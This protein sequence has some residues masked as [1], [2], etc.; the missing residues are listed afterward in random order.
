MKFM[1]RVLHTS[2]ITASIGISLAVVFLSCP[3][4]E[5]LG[6]SAYTVL[7]SEQL[8][9]E[10][11]FRLD[12]VVAGLHR[13]QDHA[14]DPDE[15]PTAS[16]PYQL[17]EVNGH[18]YYDFPPGTSILCVPLVGIMNLLGYG[19]REPGG[20]WTQKNEILVQTVLAAIICAAA[21]CVFFLVARLYLSTIQ[22]VVV[23]L[24]TALGTQIWST[25]SR[26]LW[27]HTWAILLGAL[28]LLLLLYRERR[29]SQWS[30][31]VLATT[32]SW[33]VFVRPSFALLAILVAVHVGLRQR[34]QFIVFMGV[35]FLWILVLYAYSR[36]HFH[37]RLPS[38][39]IP[40]RILG[41]GFRPQRVLGNLISPS[42]GLLIYV[43]VAA[44]V[45]FM[46]VRYFRASTDKALLVLGFLGVAVHLTLVLGRFDHWWGGHCYGARLTSDLIPFLFLIAVVALHT[47]H[48][49]V[50]SHGRPPR[51]A[52]LESVVGA[53]LLACS[54]AINGVGAC[55]RDAWHWSNHPTNID[56]DQ[57]RLWDWSR[58]QFMAPFVGLHKDP[59]RKSFR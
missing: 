57:S 11:T 35:A 13:R 9:H 45:L 37:T 58:P 14:G 38:Y 33:A 30:A 51:L 47:R 7:L 49:Y 25:A 19:S 44:W 28:S 29:S 34:K 1:R 48:E 2:I 43:P 39:Y 20:R 23:A 59:H 41:Q 18:I 15:R 42:R 40:H 31:A 16:L 6:D 4:M 17:H 46:G 36:Y 5:H 53:V 24:G 22:S 26:A 54:I 12:D 8:L 56:E 27:S 55:S 52:T 3:N 50:L 21:G 10:G 32:L